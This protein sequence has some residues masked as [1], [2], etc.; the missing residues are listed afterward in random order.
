MATRKAPENE[1]E[2]AS[3][4]RKNSAGSTLGGA[5][6]TTNVRRTDGTQHL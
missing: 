2:N 5:T 6:A 4:R 3:K 1:E